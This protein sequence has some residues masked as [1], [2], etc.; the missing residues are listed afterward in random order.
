LHWS[1]KAQLNQVGPARSIELI[2]AKIG[3]GACRI[4]HSQTDTRASAMFFTALI[5][6][7]PHIFIYIFHAMQVYGSEREIKKRSYERE[8]F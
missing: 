1:L 4:A 5:S 3:A 6:Q 2:F 7:G 8:I